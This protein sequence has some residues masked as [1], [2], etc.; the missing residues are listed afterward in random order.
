MDRLCPQML[1]VLQTISF[2]VM[3]RVSF[4]FGTRLRPAYVSCADRE[5]P[6]ENENAF[7]CNLSR[8]HLPLPLLN[9]LEPWRVHQEGVVKHVELVTEEKCECLKNEQNISRS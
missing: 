6:T 8:L 7:D 4:I 1:E 5:I 3:Q 9:S 2:F